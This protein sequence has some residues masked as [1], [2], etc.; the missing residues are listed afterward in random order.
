MYDYIYI[1]LMY[2]YM[3]VCMYIYIYIH[4]YIY[5]C[6]YISSAWPGAFGTN[7][8]EGDT[9]TFVSLPLSLSLSLATEL[10]PIPMFRHWLNR[11]LA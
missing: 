5:I 6:M 11:S 7:A 9:V 4:I 10:R 8:A 2:M 3:Y 1:Y